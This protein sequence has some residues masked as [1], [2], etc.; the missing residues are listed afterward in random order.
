MIICGI[1]ASVVI[2]GGTD[3]AERVFSNP[4]NGYATVENVDT[5]FWGDDTG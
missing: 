4:S 3:G 2:T 5:G 1:F